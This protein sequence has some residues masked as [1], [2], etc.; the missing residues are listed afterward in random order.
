MGDHGTDPGTVCVTRSR[1]PLACG[2]KPAAACMQTAGGPMAVLPLSGTRRRTETRCA[3]IS[4]CGH[5]Q[6]STRATVVSQHD[7]L[8][9]PGC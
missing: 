9:H 6:R 2:P 5:P 3:H 7:P 4:R 8:L 1:Q